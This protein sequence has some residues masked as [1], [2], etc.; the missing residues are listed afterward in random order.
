MQ[1][2]AQSAQ[3]MFWHCSF[4]ASNNFNS[5]RRSWNFLLVMVWPFFI[6]LEY[7]C[8]QILQLS[9]FT[10]TLENGLDDWK[11][12]ETSRVCCKNGVQI[13]RTNTAWQIYFKL[14]LLLKH[15]REQLML[16]L[17]RS[18]FEWRIDCACETGPE[19]RHWHDYEFKQGYSNLF[20]FRLV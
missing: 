11:T 8:Q 16:L 9:V 7:E 13:R 14:V 4:V 2:K 5:N 17:M 1:K 18:A 15:E 12:N 19:Q 10:R 3:N 6:A 20:T